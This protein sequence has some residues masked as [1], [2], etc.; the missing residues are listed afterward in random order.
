MDK[1]E[2]YL[3]LKLLVVIFV[4]SYLLLFPFGQLFSIEKVFLAKRIN[5]PFIDFVAFLA[6]F[7]FLFTRRKKI[8]PYLPYFFN[9]IIVSLF[10]L[11]V[12]SAFLKFSEL[13][14][15][16]L[17]L[18]RLLIYLL[19]SLTIFNLRQDKKLRLAIFEMNLVSL[20]IFLILGF[21]QF[22]FFPDLRSLKFAGWDDHLGRLTST[23]LDPGFASLVLLA[24][25]ISYYSLF[26]KK[27][28]FFFLFVSILFLWGVVLTFARVSFLSFFLVLLYFT[29]LKRGNFRL[30]LLI[31]LIFLAFVFISPKSEGEGTKLLRT[32]SVK[33][34]LVNYTQSLE[35]IK[36]NPLL[37]VG[38]NN[39][40]SIK[41]RLFNENPLSHS[42]SGADS[43]F[44]LVFATTGFLGGMVFLHSLWAIWKSISKSFFSQ[45]FK[46]LAIAVLFS[47]NFI[48]SLF[49]PWIIGI[50][51]L[52]LGL[53]SRGKKKD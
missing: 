19:F 36:L 48:N 33:S 35:I 21:G 52:Y 4:F 12:F 6:S 38:F 17:Y 50:L 39:V 53:S 32:A 40:C 22:I 37:G 8:P 20:F 11:L 30:N 14:F 16:V 51:A 5:I 10:S 49:Y 7:T 34:R 2:R 44:L 29:F 13:L 31:F 9:F 27:R 15:G 45:I 23:L 24:G 28:S 3:N 47:S 1:R 42:C 43:S 25:F 46:P 18:F 26:L 41:F